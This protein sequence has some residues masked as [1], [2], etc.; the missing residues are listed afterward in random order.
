MFAA[1]MFISVLV[2]IMI[3]IGFY[4]VIMMS[5][6]VVTIP[7]LIVIGSWLIVGKRINEKLELTERK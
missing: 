5:N 3:S 6:Y 1:W 7:L 4:M 2:G